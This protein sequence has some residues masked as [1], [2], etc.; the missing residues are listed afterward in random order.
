M[1]VQRRKRAGR[2]DIVVIYHHDDPSILKHWQP[3]EDRVVHSPNTAIPKNVTRKSFQ[4]HI[5]RMGKEIQPL[6]ENWVRR[7]IE[8]LRSS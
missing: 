5:T 6:Y 2:L 8:T 7:G 4:F 3:G 1:E